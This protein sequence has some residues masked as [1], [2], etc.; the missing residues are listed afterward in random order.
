MTLAELQS[1][2]VILSGFSAGGLLQTSVT[3]IVQV[4]LPGPGHA[5]T[6]ASLAAAAASAAGAWWFGCGTPFL[7]G[8]CL[9]AL[10]TML[11]LLSGRDLARARRVYPAVAVVVVAA[12]V[13]L[14]VASIA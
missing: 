5:W 11:V 10:S 12:F 6:V 14:V 2:A 13:L 8:A 9:L 1:M 3:G 7:V 4:A